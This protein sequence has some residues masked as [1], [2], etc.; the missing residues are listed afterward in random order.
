MPVMNE[1]PPTAWAVAGYA[2]AHATAQVSWLP[3]EDLLIPFFVV[4]R[5]GTRQVILA[6]V[7]TQAE[8]MAAEKK[9]LAR[10][11]GTTDAWAF[12]RE[13]SYRPRDLSASVSQDPVDA[14]LIDFWA[15]GMKDPVSLIQKFQ[16]SQ[17]HGAFRLL[18]DP[19]LAIGGGILLL[20]AAPVHA[21]LGQ[22][23]R[24]HPPVAA[25][26]DRWG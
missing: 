20:E 14:F 16:R 18:D 26:G 7:S 25:L 6:A 15:T 1:I 9:V 3:N 13:G 19:I 10:F 2:L 22:G 21:S 17:K 11:S 4:E 5:S 12:S 23:I 8:A 24:Q